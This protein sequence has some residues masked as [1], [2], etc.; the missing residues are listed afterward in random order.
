VTAAF[1]KQ[2]DLAPFACSGSG[3][4][5]I[6]FTADLA[7]HSRAFC[8]NSAALCSASLS[9]IRI[10]MCQWFWRLRSIHSLIPNR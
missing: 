9:F 3:S 1:L 7:S 8:R 6:R 5:R 2:R 10:C 4:S